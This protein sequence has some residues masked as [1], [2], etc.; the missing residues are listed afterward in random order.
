MLRRV[1]KGT[2]SVLLALALALGWPG[3]NL[4]KDL[5]VIADDQRVGIFAL[6]VVLLVLQQIYLVLPR[7]ASRSA[8]EERREIALSFL[9][10]FLVR[11]HK[12]LGETPPPI[13]RA[14]VMLL[15]KRARGLLGSYLK[16]Y[17]FA[18]P[19]GAVYS[20]EERGLTWKK[21]E[22]TCGWAWESREMSIYDSADPRYGLPADRLNKSQTSIVGNSIRSWLGVPILYNDSVVGVL[23]L[24]SEQNIDRTKFADE[25]V[26]RL[27]AA[28]ARDIGALCFQ[29]G[30]KAR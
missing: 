24:D 30:V 7:P 6:L 23:N 11:Y 19:E 21:R 29:D 18:C 26:Y 3:T 25:S 1:L 8:V 17:Y 15:T 28:C 5:G 22:G 27:A 10:G 12:E 13:V 4:L 20:N 14:N 2:G 16:I 9:K